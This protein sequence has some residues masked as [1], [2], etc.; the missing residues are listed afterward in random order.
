[1]LR[2]E[3]IDD[4]SVLGRW[5]AEWDALAVATGRP[6]S[7]PAWMLAWWR[8]AAPPGADLRVVVATDGDDLIGVA[9]FYVERAYGGLARYRVVASLRSYRAEPISVAG[10]ERE[11][12]AAFTHALAGADPRPDLVSFDLIGADAP[13]V[14]AFA[15]TW[16]GHGE[17]WL[18]REKA[19]V[20]PTLSFHTQERGFDVWFASRS[21]NFREQL[22]RGRRQLEAHGAVVDM[23][24]RDELPLALA[25]LDRLHRSR[26]SGRGGSRVL[27]GGVL[28]MLRDAGEALVDRGRFRLWSITV[29]GE[30]I[31][32]NLFVEAGGEVAYW[33][34]GFDDRWAAQR[35]SMVSI[36]AA[37]EHAWATGDHRMDLGWGGAPYKYRFADGEYSL[38]WW[39]LVP[40]SR[41]YL[42][43]RV[44][45]LPKDVARA[46]NR[47]L[48]EGARARLRT[49][50]RS[51]PD[52]LR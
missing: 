2:A 26:W 22:R 10:R 6:F 45:L 37:V 1:M 47:H 32:S 48:P 40:R 11:A 7:A 5:E 52:W 4:L 28:E 46:V 35:P 30:A 39:T 43:T 9:P 29:D 49:F 12:A 18:H 31:C 20:A 21:K 23:A 44:G 24:T 42:R 8:R 25:Q 19:D 14:G 41:R 50:S 27:D 36:L 3:V 51:R 38:E 33:L 15:E 13:W 34:G 17:P 16:P